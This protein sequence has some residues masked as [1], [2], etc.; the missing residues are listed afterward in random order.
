MRAER[1][2][3][4]FKMKNLIIF[5]CAVIIV[6]GVLFGYFNNIVKATECDWASPYKCEAFRIIGICI[7]PAGVILGYVEI[8]D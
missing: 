2:N 8:E 4:G 5:I 7:P 1:E 3:W 6:F